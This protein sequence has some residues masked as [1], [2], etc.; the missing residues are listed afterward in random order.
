V[1]HSR[2]TGSTLCYIS[3]PTILKPAIFNKETTR[4]NICFGISNHYCR[5]CFS[6][7]LPVCQQ[8]ILIALEKLADKRA[9][10]TRTP[11]RD[12]YRRVSTMLSLSF[13]QTS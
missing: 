10:F 8:S 13:R 9:I 2:G 7:D 6:L 3:L 4:G 5:D 11:N 12:E 1:Q